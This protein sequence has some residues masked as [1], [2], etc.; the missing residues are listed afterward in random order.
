MS[1]H[2]VLRVFPGFTFVELFSVAE[3]RQSAVIGGLEEC[4]FVV[5]LLHRIVTR[6]SARS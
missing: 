5:V 6:N 4:F 3:C 1:K 2:P